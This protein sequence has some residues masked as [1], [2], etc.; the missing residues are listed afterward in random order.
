[1]KLKQLA[2]VILIGSLGLSAV[3]TAQQANTPTASAP[4][5]D[6]DQ[7]I[8]KSTP[9]PTGTRLG[10]GRECHTKKEWDQRQK[11]AEDAVMH[12]Q[13]IGHMGSGPGH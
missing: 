10:G 12:G 2:S 7:I 5:D 1:M 8:C 11:D 4:A 13:Q 6:P 3:A 9:P